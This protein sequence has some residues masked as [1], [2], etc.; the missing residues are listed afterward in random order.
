FDIPIV[1][2]VDVPGFMP[3]TKQEYGGLI[4]NGA[5]LLFAYAEATVPK[6]TVITRKAYGGA[7]DVMSSKHLRGDVNYA[8][9]SAEIA[10]MGAKGAVEIIFRKEAGDPEALAAR[11]AEYKDRFA[12][13]FVAARLGYIDDVIMPH[14]TRRRLIRALASLKNKQAEN[15]WKKH[16]NIPL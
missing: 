16:D 11:E 3:G 4:K 1:T 6:L 5:K 9:P 14:G 10:V 2:F 12:N 13:P 7:Y 8:W 15:P